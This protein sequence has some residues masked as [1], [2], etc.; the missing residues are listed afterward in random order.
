M[1]EPTF[2]DNKENSIPKPTAKCTVKPVSNEAAK[3]SVNRTIERKIERS[4]HV[5]R[6][7]DDYIERTQDKNFSI[8]ELRKEEINKLLIGFFGGDDTAEPPW[9]GMKYLGPKT[10]NFR[11][12]EYD[13]QRNKKDTVEFILNRQWGPAVRKVDKIDLDLDVEFNG[14]N[15]CM[16]VLDK[17]Q[18]VAH[19]SK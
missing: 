8:V 3:M 15:S 9:P 13:S 7:I 17:I 10:G 12:Y 5:Q 16:T 18:A 2:G 19:Q 6:M 1:H 11:P 4:V 14:E